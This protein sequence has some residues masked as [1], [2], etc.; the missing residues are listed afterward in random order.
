M[1][2][3]SSARFASKSRMDTVLPVTTSRS[4]KSGALVPSASIVEGTAMKSLSQELGDP[5]SNA[6]DRGDDPLA[7]EP[8][9]GAVVGLL[10]LVRPSGGGQ[11]HASDLVAL[12]LPREVVGR[13]V[14][15]DGLVRQ[16]ER[17]VMLRTMRQ[18]ARLS[19]PPQPLGA[20]GAL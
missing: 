9:E 16:C 15:R 14:D 2:I 10:R 17:F 12:G 13:L 19:H 7:F 1:N 20:R 5:C 18:E 4:S 8:L 11:H 6:L 3:T